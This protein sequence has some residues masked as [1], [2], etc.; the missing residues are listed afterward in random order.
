MMFNITVPYAEGTYVLSL[1]ADDFVVVNHSSS[2]EKGC[3]FLIDGKE[4]DMTILRIKYGTENV[5]KR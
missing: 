1:K 4:E 3:Y 5:W 2:R